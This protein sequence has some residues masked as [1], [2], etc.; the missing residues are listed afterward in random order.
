MSV[1]SIAI[2]KGGSGKTTTAINLAAALQRM[3][4]KVLLF[5]A[6]PQANLS[7]SLG[8]LDEPEKNLFTELKKE[9]AGE[10]G[11]LVQTIIQ[12]RS[13]LPLVPSSIEL[14]GAELEL[15]SVYGREQV[16]SWMLESLKEKYDFIFIDCPPAIGMLTV[17]ALVASDYVLMPLQAEF[18]P[19]KGLR[20]FMHHFKAVKSKLN[21]NLEVL[22]FILTRYDERKTMNRQVYQ[23][24]EQEFGEKAFHTHIRN[25]I[26]L[27]K[28]QEAGTDIFSFDKHAH[29]AEDYQ[30]LALEFIEK[31]AK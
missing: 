25:N 14:A 31:I 5:D 9:I 27:A 19:L 13:G 1:I 10:S 20:S 12:T 11:D 16:F 7:Q 2:Q 15:V 30:N 21:R 18:L 23:Q 22:G 28:A 4:K 3:G 6:D 24:L 8:V 29:G 26:Q 17:N